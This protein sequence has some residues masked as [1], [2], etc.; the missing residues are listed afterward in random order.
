MTQITEFLPQL[1][2]SYIDIA[3]SVKA[4]AMDKYNK[5]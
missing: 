5:L 4:T 3:N 1:I 2:K